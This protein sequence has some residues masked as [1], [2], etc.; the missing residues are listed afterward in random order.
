M[1]NLLID[2]TALAGTGAVLAGCYL[3][4][5]LANTLIIGGVLLIAYALTVARRRKYAA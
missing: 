4:Y 2:G 1:K 3:K 5:G